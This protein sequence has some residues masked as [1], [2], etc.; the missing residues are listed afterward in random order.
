MRFTWNGSG[1]RITAEA[2]KSLWG[3]SHSQSERCPHE[4]SSTCNHEF[5]HYKISSSY[6]RLRAV[7]PGAAHKEL[8][9]C[10]TMHWWVHSCHQTTRDQEP[11]LWHVP[12]AGG[13]RPTAHCRPALSRWESPQQPLHP[14]GFHKSRRQSC[15]K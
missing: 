8:F 13:D 9:Q 3:C 5:H 15:F 12:A 14:R 2:L 4:A 10:S 7:M 6:C 11:T 1:Q